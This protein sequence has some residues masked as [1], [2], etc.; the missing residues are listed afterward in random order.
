MKNIFLSYSRRDIKRVEELRQALIGQGYRPWIDPNPRPGQDWR[1]EIDDAIK[2]ADAMVVVITPESANSIYVT[3]EWAYAMGHDVPVFVVVFHPAPMHPRLQSIGEIFDI[4]GF[5]DE[6]HFWDYFLREFNRL[7][8][9]QPDKGSP[10]AAVQPSSQ[11][12]Q[13][14]SKPS[15]AKLSPQIPAYDKSVMPTE[16]GYWI[17]IRRGPKLNT[18][19]KLDKDIVTLGRDVANDIAINDPEVSRYH[20]KLLKQGDAYALEDLGSTNGTQING[21]KVGGITP[22]KDGDTIMLGDAI[23]LSYDLA[24]R[25]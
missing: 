25:S 20:L 10:P 6:N 5:T 14:P 22:L 16:P 8:A 18:M 2:N 15:T 7:M 11:S 12:A 13:P 1:F 4:T 19:F 3:Y 23:I 17:V 21:I 9:Q 24:Y